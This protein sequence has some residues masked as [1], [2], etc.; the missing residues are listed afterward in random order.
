M[1][2]RRR[3]LLIGLAVLLVAPFRSAGAPIG[4]KHSVMVDKVAAKIETTAEV[5][6]STA[7]RPLL[8][9]L[10]EG[11]T[12]VLPTGSE[13]WYGY[14]EEEGF[15]VSND[16]GK[17]WVQHNNGL[18]RK[19]VYPF[20]REQVRSITALG[21]DPADPDRV[22]LSTMDRLYLSENRGETWR[23]I[24]FHAGP[25]TAVA[26]SPHHPEEI[27]VG[28]SFYGIYETKDLGENW[29]RISRDLTFLNLSS[30]NYE[31]ISALVYHPENPDKILFACGFG[32]G[33]YLY[34]KALKIWEALSLSRERPLI[35]NLYFRLA[36]ATQE[37]TDW[38]LQITQPEG[39]ELYSW[40]QFKLVAVEDP[41]SGLKE[42]AVP[43]ERRAKAEG[44]FGIYVR[45]DFA[46][47]RR[48]DEHLKF[49]KQNGLN[50]LVVDF[51]DD[52]GY[53]TYDT[54]VPLAHTIGAVR[55]RIK[56]QELIKKAKTEN[57][58]IIGRLVVF[59][60]SCL[61]RY[62]NY[63]YAAW[64]KEQNQPWRYLVRE[65][66]AAGEVTYVQ[67]EHWVDPFSR[68]VWEYN[69]ALAEELQALGIDEIQFD[70]IRFP[71]DGDLARCSYRYQPPGAEKID[72]L[73]SF[74]AMA[75]ERLS[76]PIS[77]DLYGFNCWYLMEGRT[78][79][80]ISLFSKYVDVICPMY[81]PSH[82]PSDFLCEDYLERAELIYQEGTFRAETLVTEG[83]LIRPYVQ[84]FRL[85]GR[86]LRMTPPVYTD[87]LLRQVRGVLSSTAPGF[88]LWNN[89]NH[90]YMVNKSL[91][92]LLAEHTAAK[93]S[94]E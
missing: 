62:N 90:Y 33:L 6:V 66:N 67:R 56:I 81:Y 11:P 61:Y 40:P 36:S 79:Q 85:S 86:E 59:K 16:A 82:F 2:R 51:K 60:D 83:C 80:N 77:T 15:F 28:T 29:S 30:T 58:Y 1:N 42:R 5:E 45:S 3:F 84:A 14:A 89:S 41:R 7:V 54:K 49:L 13:L 47:G 92:E 8:G 93:G 27:L 37:R 55:P 4:H 38:L 53:V 19:L 57:L 44:K 20:R 25:V 48:L 12:F 70:Y 18:P 24:P 46:A 26:L 32:N 76:I 78:G 72:A 52:S 65:R 73:E 74:L 50:S 23:L 75:R 63:Q 31:T 64:E 10:G 94:R 43:S 22:I 68:D 35:E 87:Y 88:T 69:L 34:H 17:S 9:Q 39:V 71:T 91:K 21:V